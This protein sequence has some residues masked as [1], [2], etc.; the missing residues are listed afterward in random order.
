MKDIS[1]IEGECLLLAIMLIMIEGNAFASIMFGMHRV[2][3]RDFSSNF[4]ETLL[5][6]H[7]RQYQPVPNVYGFSH[8][9]HLTTFPVAI[10][11]FAMSGWSLLIL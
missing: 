6:L 4:P 10:L 5:L 1:F 11:P 8:I 7:N 2:E 3:G 9:H